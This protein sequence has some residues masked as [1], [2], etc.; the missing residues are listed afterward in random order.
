MFVTACPRLGARVILLGN[1]TPSCLWTGESLWKETLML[2]NKLK[3][4]AQGLFEH[5]Q[6]YRSSILLGL[7]VIGN[8]SLK[9]GAKELVPAFLFSTRW[10][11]CSEQAPLVTWITPP[12][13]SPLPPLPLPVYLEISLGL[14]IAHLPLCCHAC[15]G[16]ARRSGFRPLLGTRCRSPPWGKLCDKA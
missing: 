4:T 14:L 12:R 1:A 15:S 5:K 16:W 7:I 8:F 11:L 6:V 2:F 13:L 10:K 9:L 3:C